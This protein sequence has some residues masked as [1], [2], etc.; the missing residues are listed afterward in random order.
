MTIVLV[1]RGGRGGRWWGK[2]GADEGL[3][4]E[5][6]RRPLPNLNR[7]LSTQEGEE[8]AD[9]ENDPD[10]DPKV[11]PRPPPPLILSTIWCSGDLLSVFLAQKL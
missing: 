5:L 11:S 10:Y 4:V 3:F 6:W 2:A 7:A 8:E 1:W 9:E